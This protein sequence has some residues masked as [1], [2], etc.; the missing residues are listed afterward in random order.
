[1]WS[2]IRIRSLRRTLSDMLFRK[3]EMLSLLVANL[4]W[5]LNVH[6][7]KWDHNQ[8]KGIREKWKNRLSYAER[9]LWYTFLKISEKNHIKEFWLTRVFLIIDGVKSHAPKLFLLKDLCI[10]CNPTLSNWNILKKST[11]FWVKKNVRKAK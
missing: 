5:C 6:H 3:I 9:S 10:L 2:L 7:Q 4:I 8:K 11:V 1:M